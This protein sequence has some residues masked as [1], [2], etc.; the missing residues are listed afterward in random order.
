ME[1]RRTTLRWLFVGPATL[2]TW[3]GVFLIG[4]VAYQATEHA[5]CPEGQM[6][7]GICVNPRVQSTLEVVIYIFAGISAIAVELAAAALAPSHKVVVSWV[8]FIA[9][10]W[11]AILLGFLANAYGQALTA[12]ACGLITPI[13]MG[14]LLRH[15]RTAPLSSAI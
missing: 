9:G 4:L 1:S 14:A 6:V 3:F 11:A 15:R 2:A 10:S 8:T 12:I 13:V 5:V 7:S